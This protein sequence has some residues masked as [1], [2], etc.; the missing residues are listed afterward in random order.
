MDR[1]AV[2]TGEVPRPL[3][4]IRILSVEA[5]RSVIEISMEAVIGVRAKR[6]VLSPTTAWSFLTGVDDQR[7]DDPSFA[8]CSE[9]HL[10]IS[11]KYIELRIFFYGFFY[12]TVPVNGCVSLVGTQTTYIWAILGPDSLRNQRSMVEATGRLQ[13]GTSVFSQTLD[14]QWKGLDMALTWPWTQP[15]QRTGL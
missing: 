14:L 11:T 7:Y 15:M 5:D 2:S 6:V 12:G 10:N 9:A 3:R 4:H 8:D 13:E 1:H